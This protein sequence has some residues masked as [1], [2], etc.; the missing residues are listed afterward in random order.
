MKKNTRG[1]NSLLKIPKV[2]TEVGRKTF[3][4][5][6]ARRFNQLDASAGNETS[7]LKFRQT[8]Y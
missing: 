6:G 5:Q 7:I 1:N 2:R 4:F 8:F 3:A